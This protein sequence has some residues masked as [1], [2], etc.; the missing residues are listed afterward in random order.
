MSR[1]YFK[2]INDIKH[3]TMLG[4]RTFPIIT[5]ECHERM[6]KNWMNYGRTNQ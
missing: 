6:L 3:V 5:E 2:K 1:I 4:L